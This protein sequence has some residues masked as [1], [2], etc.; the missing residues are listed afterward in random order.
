MPFFQDIDQISILERHVSRLEGLEMSQARK[1]LKQYKAARESLKAQM[2]MAPDN[3]FTEAKLKSALIQIEVGIKEL[4]HRINPELV[5]GFE[6]LTEQGVEDSVREV[7]AFEKHFLGTSAPLPV[8]A[9]IESTEPEN[10]LLNQFQASV[11]AYSAGLRGRFQNVLT[12]SLLQKK[13]WTQAVW[14][15]EAVFNEEEWKLARI[16]RTEL[17]NIYG[18]SKMNGFL[19]IRDEYVPDLMKTLYHPMDGRTGQDSI[20]AASLKLIV[21]LEEPFRYKW[22]GRERVFMSPPDR[23]NDRSILVPYRTAYE[24]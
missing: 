13:T 24:K 4:Q 12:Q 11:E 8:D 21:P 2:L 3:S 17:H 18:I 20:E 19:G 1:V 7:N 15:M 6:Y 22:K 9:I 5:S 10:L 14:D 23:P 16:V